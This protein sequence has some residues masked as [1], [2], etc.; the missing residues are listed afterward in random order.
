MACFTITR[1]KDIE[2][3]LIAL[4]DE[5]PILGSKYQDYLDFKQVVNLMLNKVHLTTEGIAEILVIKS[6]IK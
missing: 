1:S 3:K 5:Y 6:R 4:L 2:D